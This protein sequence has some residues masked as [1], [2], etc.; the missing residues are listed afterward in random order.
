M[1][2]FVAKAA[3]AAGAEPD[4]PPKVQELLAGETPQA[5]LPRDSFSIKCNVA[6]SEVV[7]ASLAQHSVVCSSHQTEM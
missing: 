1:P 7:A 4:L 5:Q 6:P 3:N 2:P